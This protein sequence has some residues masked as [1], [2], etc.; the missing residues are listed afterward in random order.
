MLYF[1]VGFIL[2]VALNCRNIWH[3][4]TNKALGVSSEQVGLTN[5]FSSFSGNRLTQILLWALLGLWLYVV[6]WFLRGIIV[7]I[8]NDVIADEYLHPKNYHRA[9]YWKS[10]VGLKVFFIASLVVTILYT[11]FAISLLSEL[12]FIFYQAIE[13][14]KWGHS[15]LV[16]SLGILAAGLITYV[17]VTLVHLSVNSVRAIYKNF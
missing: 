12:S 9:Q 7:N 1:M 3:Y 4:F 15:S 6:F 16:W 17:F 10:V 14:F 13:N 5:F 11:I 2:L 8:Y